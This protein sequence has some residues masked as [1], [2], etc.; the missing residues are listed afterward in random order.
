MVVVVAAAVWQL[1]ID[2]C[3]YLAHA[4]IEDF[5]RL[6]R[7][8]RHT[9]QHELI[10]WHKQPKVVYILLVGLFCFGHHLQQL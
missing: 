3:L 1:T 9:V 4:L 2:G 10:M 5:V 6:W 7:R 8:L